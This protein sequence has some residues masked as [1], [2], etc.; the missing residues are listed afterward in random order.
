MNKKYFI[1]PTIVIF[2]LMLF[3]EDMEE[4]E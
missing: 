1:A 2:F 3:L 4:L